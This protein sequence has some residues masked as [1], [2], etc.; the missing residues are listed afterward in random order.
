MALIFGK[1][2]SEQLDTLLEGFNS[3]ELE[4]PVHEFL[5]VSEDEYTTFVREGAEAVTHD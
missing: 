1:Y 5:N 2:T 3:M 4:I